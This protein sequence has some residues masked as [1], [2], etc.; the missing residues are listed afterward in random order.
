MSRQAVPVKV[1]PNMRLTVRVVD[2]YGKEVGLFNPARLIC[3]AE[4]GMPQ[5]L[6]IAI[7]AP[8]V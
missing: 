2:D 5:F 8:G 6:A 7:Y 3:P 4:D 1:V